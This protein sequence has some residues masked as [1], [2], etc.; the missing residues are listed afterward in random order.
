MVTLRADWT[1]IHR[2][3][4][5]PVRQYQPV[6]KVL[7]SQI[8]CDYI[9]SVLYGQPVIGSA[10]ISGKSHVDDAYTT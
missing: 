4:N 3:C 1:H 8:E 2:R 7:L 9:I 10:M 6:E 5:I